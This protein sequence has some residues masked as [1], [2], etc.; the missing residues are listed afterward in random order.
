MFRPLAAPAAPLLGPLDLSSDL[1][2]DLLRAQRAARALLG[3]DH[4][5]AD[6][7]QEALVALW[8]QPEPPPDRRGWLVRAVVFRARHLR[9][10]LRRRQRHECASASHCELH[11]GCDNPLHI[12]Y[13]HELGERL[14]LALTALPKEQRAPFELWLATG[15]DYRGIAAELGLPVGTVRSRLHRARAALQQLLA[16]EQPAD[17]GRGAELARQPSGKPEPGP[18]KEPDHGASA[19]GSTGPG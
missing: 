13:A 8:Q 9:R 16:D 7:C 17:S 2:A 11:H 5:A 19:A 4:L 18:G 6:A 12:A 1:D 10:T 14:D 15:L 3:C